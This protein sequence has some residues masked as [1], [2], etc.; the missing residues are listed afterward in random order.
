[1]TALNSEVPSGEAELEMLVNI[2]KTPGML[3]DKDCNPPKWKDKRILLQLLN[4]SLC[5]KMC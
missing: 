4:G 2:R 5:P 1:M 3:E